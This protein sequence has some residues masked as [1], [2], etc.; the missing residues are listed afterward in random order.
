MFPGNSKFHQHQVSEESDTNF[1]IDADLAILG[2]SEDVYREYSKRIRREYNFYP[3]VIYMP[4]R[5]KV[6]K[7]FLDMS[8]IF[9]TTYFQEKYEE[10]AKMNLKLELE[11][12][13]S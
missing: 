9:K 3:D 4:G 8:T 6:L 12:L 7:R 11:V 2:A 13:A 5:K 1:F 10:K